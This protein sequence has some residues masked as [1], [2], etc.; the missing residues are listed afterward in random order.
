VAKNNE[1]APQEAPIQTEGGLFE[2]LANSVRQGG[3]GVVA[4]SGAAP[5]SR[6]VPETRYEDVGGMRETV[7]LVREAVELPITHPEIFQ[8]LGIRPHKGILFY[9]RRGPGRPCSRGRSRT[10]AGRTL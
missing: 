3:A 9:G 10:R 7:A 5:G 6:N 4:A 8:R 2:R 1:T